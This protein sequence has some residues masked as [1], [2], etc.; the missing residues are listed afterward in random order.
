MPLDLYNSAF[1]EKL[2]KE[3]DLIIVHIT[4]LTVLI[5]AEHL[6]KLVYD[7]ENKSLYT[8]RAVT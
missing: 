5:D 6:I 1:A 3:A 2:G 8:A 4:A 7:S